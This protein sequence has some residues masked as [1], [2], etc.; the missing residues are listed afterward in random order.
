MD[1][2]CPELNYATASDNYYKM[3][4]EAKIVISTY[5]STTIHETVAMNIPTIMFLR[6]E[7]WEL[8]PTAIPYFDKLTNC[9]VFHNSPQSAARMVNKVWDDVDGWWQSEEVVDACNEFKMWFCRESEDP[10]GELADFCKM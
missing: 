4:S 7:H 8:P 5:N 10:I 1:D 6:R 3:S 2:L 9:G